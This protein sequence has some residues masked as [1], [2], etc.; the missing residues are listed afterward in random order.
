VTLG[1][2]GRITLAVEQGKRSIVVQGLRLTVADEEDGG[3]ARR[4]REPE[5]AVLR[6]GPETAPGGAP[7]QP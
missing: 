7:T 6:H 5:L 2:Q 4:W 3:G 1:G